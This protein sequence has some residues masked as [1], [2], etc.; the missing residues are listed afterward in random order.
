[1]IFG[2]PQ[3]PG[4]THGLDSNNLQVHLAKVHAVSL[5]SIEMV[6][7]SDGAASSAAVADRDVL[8][9]GSS[10]CDR[11][12]VDLLVLPDGVGSAVGS[13]RTLLGARLGESLRTFDYVV[14]DEWAR[15]PSVDGQGGKT[16]GD[17]E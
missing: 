10:S 3:E 14:L 6:V 5:P 15:R 2:I 16:A 11:W 13:D 7:E 1:M 4:G 8:V 9:E 17:R 12:L